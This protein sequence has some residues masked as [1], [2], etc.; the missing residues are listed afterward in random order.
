VS[1][2]SQEQLKQKYLM[3]AKYPSPAACS[4]DQVITTE[5]NLRWLVLLAGVNNTEKQTADAEGA[6]LA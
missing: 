6:P 2:P 1:A 5:H 4:H 3:P